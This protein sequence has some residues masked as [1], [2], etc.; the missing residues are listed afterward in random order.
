MSVTSMRPDRRER[1]ARIVEC[2]MCE[3][4]EGVSGKM[5]GKIK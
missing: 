5:S 4:F 2:P 1:R 3:H